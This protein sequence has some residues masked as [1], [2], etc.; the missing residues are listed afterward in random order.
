MSNKHEITL[1]QL[2]AFKSV[3]DSQ[4]YTKAA[5][6]T[7]VSQSGISH[8][9][10]RL[11]DFFETPLF[12]YN[13]RNISGLTPVGSKLY[14]FTT[15]I[16]TE[17]NN[18]NSL[19]DFSRSTPKERLNIASINSV[20]TSYL[21]N[22][23]NNKIESCIRNV[24]TGFEHEVERWVMDGIADIGFTT[25]ISNTI[26]QKWKGKFHWKVAF[27]DELVVIVP[28]AHPLA[29]N[30]EVSLDQASDFPLIISSGG[31]EDL[32]YNFFEESGISRSELVIRLWVNN[33]STLIQMARNDVGVSIVPRLALRKEDTRGI[34]TLSLNPIL[35]R[36]ILVFG[37]T[38]N[39]SRPEIKY[40]FENFKNEKNNFNY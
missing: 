25:D 34:E 38:D 31:C 36:S 39:M 14:T 40:F 10:T 19:A 2:R 9:L 18:I 4:S 23:Q 27:Q 24:L 11:E 28:K 16:I 35:Y 7:G 13:G 20:A 8:S 33:F 1:T 30:L 6:C 15:N 3:A 29:N 12:S 17:L 22:I 32:V 37:L 21:N 26:S 5:S